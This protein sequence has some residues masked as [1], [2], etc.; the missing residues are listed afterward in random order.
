VID[1]GALVVAGLAAAYFASFVGYGV[2]LEDEGLILFQIARTA[3]GE[4]PYVDFH[5]GYTP[6]AF[7]LNAALQQLF[8]DSV[9]PLR[10]GLV[11]VNALGIA[12]IY[13]LARAWTR[14][15]LAA[16]AALGYAAFLPFFVGDFASFNVPY[17]SWYASLAFLACQWCMDR[18]LVRGRASALLGA[19]LLVGLAFTF[20]P[21]S[22]VLAVLATGFVLAVLAA[23][24]GD[25]DRRLARSLLVAGLLVL[26]VG[27]G[28]DVVNA[29][30]PTI[31]GPLALLVLG[32][33]RARAPV[34]NPR[35]L[36]PAVATVAGGALLVSGPWIAYFVAR[37]GPTA[38]V[39]EVLLIGSNAE[40]IYATPYPVPIGFPASWPAVLAVGLVGAGMAGLL[41]ERG[42]VR[43]RRAFFGVMAAAGVS[44]GLLAA[45]ARMPEGVTRSIV[46][47]AQHVG[48]FLVPLMGAASVAY[49]LRRLRVPGRFDLRQRRFLGTVVFALAMYVSLYPRVDTMH[50][51]IALPSALVLAAACTERMVQ[52][53]AAMLAVPPAAARASAVVAAAALALVAAVPNYA[54]LVAPEHVTL[55]SPR[56]PI[57]VERGRG[58]D[59]EALNATLAY[60]RPRL[61]PGEPLFAFPALS[62]VPFALGH[63]TPTP[64]DYFFAGR[65][66]HV[67]EAEIVRALATARPRYLVTL[68]RRLG[69]FSESPAYY[70]MIR[71][72]VAQHYRL[73]ARFG[74]YD[75][76]ARELAEAPLVVPDPVQALDTA[77]IRR[78]L[79]DPDR[80]RRRRA[81]RA[82]LA[83]VETPDGL[84]AVAREVA[85]DE[86]TQL[87]LLRN[88]G[89]AGDLRALDWLVETF[90]TARS[91]V[92]G[93]AA[94]ALTFFALRDAT[95]PYLFG[96][97][98][99]GPWTSLAASVERLPMDEVRHW[100]D[101]YK[102]RRQI[103]VFAGRALALARDAEAV[104]AFEATLAQEQKR[105]YLQVVAAEGLLR[106]GQ[107]ERLCDLVALLARRRQDV[108]NMVP[109]L[110]IDAAARHPEVAARCVTEGLASDEELV[111]ETSAWIAGQARLDA[112]APALR[113]A[114]EDD[115]Q[116]VRIAAIW[117][118]GRM[119]DG[120]AAAS[121]RS[122]ADDGDGQVRAF[123]REALDRLERTG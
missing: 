32:R 101:D 109:S 13:V 71:E 45:W 57:R 84:A 12:M 103:G 10:W 119:G 122:L 27:F 60:L 52:A 65:P 31:V 88:L 116:A 91:R 44:T 98:P 102:L 76:M 47:Q 104:T 26:L 118:L 99:S 18:Y 113:A 14:P 82:L 115:E 68:N 108:Q 74:R 1:R 17:P 28:F 117:A 30:F 43:V 25:P 79:G 63:P 11:V 123:A 64:H 112:V 5:T 15:S 42:R 66:D 111:R 89:E 61:E 46:W 35:R 85:P 87:L 105:P 94:G 36:V 81:V 86:A 92:K 100:M 67:A 37:L 39:R 4:V 78:D 73:A 51:I 16:A 50:L 121:I 48:F 9:L 21:N 49:L 107:P 80:E 70:F 83:R 7:Y 41:A 77:E 20:K 34:E 93:E 23:G 6:G 95:E 54:G 106:L 62:L 29:E 120:A 55:A 19:G 96:P 72:H 2:N 24:D 38:F 75:V 59:L 40:Q 33:F 90:Q 22:G 56:A 69:F 110:V 58:R 3:R 114:L 8:G 53:W 97:R